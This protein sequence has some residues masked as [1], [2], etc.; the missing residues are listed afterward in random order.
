MG[1]T[2][3]YEGRLK[4]EEDYEE[5]I[6]IATNFATQNEMHYELVKEKNKR[7]E[8]IKEVSEWIYTG[9]VKGI[10]LHPHEECE[11]L[12]IEFDKDL[13]MQD[14]C[15][16]QFAGAETHIG[17]IELFRQLELHFDKFILVDEGEYYE[18]GEFKH[19]DHHIETFNERYKEMKE[20]NPH[21]IGPVKGE[22]GRIIDLVNTKEN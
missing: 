12:N 14:R 13:Y 11:R 8:R 3:H 1:V 5:V 9:P 16:T 21:L 17:I 15:K 10:L 2:I 4:S 20:N 22:N 18:T 19:L 6:R 7:L